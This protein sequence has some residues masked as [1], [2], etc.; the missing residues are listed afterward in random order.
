METSNYF[1]EVIC[2]KSVACE[3]SDGWKKKASLQGVE[4]LMSKRLRGLWNQ[5]FW[6]Q[7]LALSF[8]SGK[9]ASSFSPL[10]LTFLICKLEK[11]VYVIIGLL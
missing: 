9:L 10:C 11:T 5:I 4:S 3:V 7:R 2:L 1:E 8:I 6:I